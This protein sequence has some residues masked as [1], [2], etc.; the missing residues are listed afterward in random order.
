MSGK[1]IKGLG[2]TQFFAAKLALNPASDDG[3]DMLA[4]TQNDLAIYR[5]VA[6]P[7][8]RTAPIFK[9]KRTH[10]TSW[11]KGRI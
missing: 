10:P 5:I 4:A 9:A 6:P 3:L 11:R 7:E 1:A 8:V 2:L